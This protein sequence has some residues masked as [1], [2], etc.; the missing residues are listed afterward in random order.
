MTASGSIWLRA[1]P[2]QK[3][4]LATSFK[5]YQSTTR[6]EV[7]TIRTLHYSVPESLHQYIYMI[8]P[9]T[10]FS[11]IQ[12]QRY[13]TFDRRALG[14]T[15]VT[16]SSCSYL[17]TPTCLKG[18]YNVG[19]YK[20][21]SRRDNLLG[22]TGFLAEYVQYADLTQFEQQYAPW[23]VGANITWSSINGQSFL[24]ALC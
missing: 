13:Q 16:I 1:F 24:L 5:V 21:S 4:M 3:K 18:L 8:Q 10:R 20:P 9:T 11:Q 17:T 22:V 14:D 12:T 7:K 2:K 6:E 23:A 15:N 19:N